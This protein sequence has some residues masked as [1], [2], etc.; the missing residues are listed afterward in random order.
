MGV[1]EC[2]RKGC[3]N[4]MCDRYSTTFGYICND[5]YEEMCCSG[6]PIHIFMSM[7]KRKKPNY[8][9]ENEFKE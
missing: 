2:N 8:D 6:L 3:E 9:Y 1:K 7:D 5:C 4:I